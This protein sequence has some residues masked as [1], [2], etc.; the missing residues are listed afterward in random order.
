MQANGY[1]DQTPSRSGRIE[2]VEA[3]AAGNAKIG[4]TIVPPGIFDG[5]EGFFQIPAIEHGQW[6]GGRLRGIGLEAP[7]Q[8]LGKGRIGRPIIG[9]R[10]GKGGTVESLEP[11]QRSAGRRHFQIVDFPDSFMAYLFVPFMF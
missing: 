4:L 10:P 6:L 5:I 3:P 9:E 8:A 2:K 11:V 7:I 1:S